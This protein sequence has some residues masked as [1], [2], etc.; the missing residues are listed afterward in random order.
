MSDTSQR[1]RLIGDGFDARVAAVPADRWDAGSPCPEWTARDVVG[2]VVGNHRWLATTVRGGE[3]QPMAVDEDPAEAWRDAYAGILAL[4]EDP[5]AMDELVE[6]PAGK[7]PF[8]QM[9]ARFVC[10]DVLVHT[11]DLARAV[12]G[13]EQ[14]DEGSVTQA[15]R[16]LKP[17][18]E[19]I[20]QPGFFGPKLEPPA[21]A[22]VQTEFLYFVG[23]RA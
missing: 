22:D 6:G 19:Q 20:R 9:L 8:E 16:T 18:D 12:G 3:P 10:M 23:R 11:W 15:Y 2:H 5:V 13:D 7:M 1:Y 4:A 14:L 21:D 17:M